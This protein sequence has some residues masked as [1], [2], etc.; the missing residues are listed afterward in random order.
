MLLNAFE[1]KETLPGTEPISLPADIVLAMIQKGLVVVGV[2]C[3]MVDVCEWMELTKRI[4]KVFVL[5]TNLDKLYYNNRNG[6]INKKVE[7]KDFG[8]TIAVSSEQ[9]YKELND[10]IIELSRKIIG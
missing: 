6:D 2:Q 10:K 9:D 7:K 5:K 3:G 4:I 1:S 8:Y